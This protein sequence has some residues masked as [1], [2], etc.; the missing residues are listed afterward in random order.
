MSK[1]VN[2]Y[3][4]LLLKLYI[5]NFIFNI[6]LYIY[7]ILYLICEGRTNKESQTLGA[8]NIITGLKIDQ[9]HTSCL[10]PCVRTWRSSEQSFT[11]YLQDMPP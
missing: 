9:K 11:V 4:S 6:I 8:R 10:K 7:I 1:I 2:S 5:Y 3:I